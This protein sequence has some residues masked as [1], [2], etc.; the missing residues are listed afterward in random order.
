MRDDISLCIAGVKQK[1]MERKFFMIVAEKNK[2]D[3]KI[4]AKAGASFTKRVIRDFKYNKI[5]YLM[6]TNHLISTNSSLYC[7]FVK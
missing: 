3:L 2:S 5:L 4:K 6:I 1:E 7:Y